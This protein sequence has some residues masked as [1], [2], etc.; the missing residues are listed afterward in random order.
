LDAY[1]F[2]ETATQAAIDDAIDLVTEGTARAVLPVGSAREL[3]VAVS[4]SS[5]SGLV[6]KLATV[7]T[8]DGL[9]GLETH[10]A[11]GPPPPSMPFPT[12]GSV[13]DYVGFALLQTSPASA[14]S[15][16]DAAVQVS[17]VVGAAIVGTGQVRVLVEA[18]SDSTTTLSSTLGT[19]AALTGV[20][21]SVTVTGAVANGAGFTTA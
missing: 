7:L 20:S 1:V 19:V 15:V 3:Y 18:T 17:G 11:I 4:D 21:A 13:D 6:T 2:A 10:L 12:Q 14:V 8:I 9:T 16:Y 5:T